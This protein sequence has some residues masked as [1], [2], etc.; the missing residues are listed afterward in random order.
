MYIYIY[1]Y[2]YLIFLII[3][4]SFGEVVHTLSDVLYLMKTNHF[5]RRSEKR[6]RGLTNNCYHSKWKQYINNDLEEFGFRFFFVLFFSY[7]NIFNIFYFFANTSVFLIIR[8]NE[9]GSFFFAC[10]S[11]NHLELFI[12][13]MRAVSSDPDIP[14]QQKRQR[15]G[16]GTLGLDMYRPNQSLS[17]DMYSRPFFNKFFLF[18]FL[19]HGTYVRYAKKP[20]SER[21]RMYQK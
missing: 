12:L 16:T 21:S 15:T 20:R 4:L 19:N 11:I 18:F 8:T 9:C 6:V 5:Q 2:I 3:N 13:F 7:K 17:Y 14:F 1:I 10:V